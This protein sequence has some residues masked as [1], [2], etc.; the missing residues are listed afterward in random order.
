VCNNICFYHGWTGPETGRLASARRRIM[1]EDYDDPEVEERWC[2]EQRDH[3]EEYLKAQNVV[4]GEIGEWPAWHVPPYVAVWAIESRK[5]PG[6]VGWWAIS[7]DVP[8]DYISA[9]KVKHPR[10]AMR[11]FSEV[12]GEVSG[13]ML[14]GE[15]HP[16]IRIGK[17]ED[18]PVLGDL[19][20]RR[21]EL[22]AQF[23]DD[24]SAWEE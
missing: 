6:W 15:H 17:E 23:A 2:T 20:K 9:E 10:E 21:S 18:W 1:A 16:T 12:W 22:L 11:I 19:L 3:V 13:Y 8:T 24:D 5:N 4:H 14:R 7:G